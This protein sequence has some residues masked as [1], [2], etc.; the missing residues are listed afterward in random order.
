MF[1]LIK[2]TITGL[3][4]DHPMIGRSFGIQNFKFKPANYLLSKLF[5]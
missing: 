4:K 1:P 3:P 5:Q 2:Y